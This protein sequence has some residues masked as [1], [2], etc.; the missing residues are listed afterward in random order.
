MMLHEQKEKGKTSYEIYKGD[1]PLILT[2]KKETPKNNSKSSPTALFYV[3]DSL[4]MN[5]GA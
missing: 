2:P 4:Q 1:L 5:I 3:A